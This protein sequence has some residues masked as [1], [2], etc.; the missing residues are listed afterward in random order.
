VWEITTGENTGNYLVST[1]GHAWKDFDGRDKFQA[2]DA[3]NANATMGSSL[4]SEYMSYYVLRTDLTP[5]PPPGG[6][7]PPY[8]SVLHFY[9]KPEG[10]NDFTSA[11]KQVLAAFT[12]TNTPRGQAY[13]YTLV[14]GGRGPEFVLVQ[15]RKSIGDLAGPT[16]KS[17]D[18]IMQEAY[19]D[20]GATTMSTLRKSYYRVDSELLHFRPDLSY[21]APAAKP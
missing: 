17:L 20:E 9:L 8:L 21:M 18:E 6:T 4:A 5:A 11:A 2:A 14:N 1:C 10:V 16:Q 12:K 13:F 19:G 15:D 3:A 7:L